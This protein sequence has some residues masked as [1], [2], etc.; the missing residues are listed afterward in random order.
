VNILLRQGNTTFWD[1]KR[2]INRN[3]I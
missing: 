1:Y 2:N 3:S